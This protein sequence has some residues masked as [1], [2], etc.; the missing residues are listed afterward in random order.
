MNL[1]AIGPCTETGTSSLSQAFQGFV[2][3]HYPLQTRH[4]LAPKKYSR[5][6]SNE[7]S[8]YECVWAML[9]LVDS[10]KLRFEQTRP[11]TLKLPSLDRTPE[12]VCHCPPSR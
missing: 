7:N 10:R 12:A 11:M 5:L 3:A 8:A 6:A 1:S 9:S 2:L 4:I